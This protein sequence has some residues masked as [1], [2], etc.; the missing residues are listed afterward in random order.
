MAILKLLNIL[1]RLLKGD[2]RRIPKFF[3]DPPNSGKLFEAYR[4]PMLVDARK[5]ES[6]DDRSVAVSY[7]PARE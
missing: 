5:V 2:N 1:E 3:N 4:C 7:F 6:I